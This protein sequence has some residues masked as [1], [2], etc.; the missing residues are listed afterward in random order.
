ML[1]RLIRLE[2][3]SLARSPKSILDGG[4]LANIVLIRWCIMHVYCV[5]VCACVCLCV[6][7]YM[8]I[9]KV[10]IYTHMHIYV[11]FPSV[12]NIVCFVLFSH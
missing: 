1:L 11:A 5:C 10:Y 12:G 3:F 4:W 6:C 7:L 8:Y 9:Y 2:F